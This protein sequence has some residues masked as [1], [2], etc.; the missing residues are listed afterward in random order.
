MTTD[1]RCIGEHQGIIFY[2]IGQRQGL[3]IG[4]VKGSNEQPWFVVDKNV[5][6]NELIVAQGEQHPR[7]YAQGLISGP[8]H[9]LADIQ[10]KIIL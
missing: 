5:K 10:K 2:T 7:L 3:G 6:T 4:G 8:I 1:G 9:W